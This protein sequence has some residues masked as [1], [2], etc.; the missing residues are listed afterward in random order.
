MDSYMVSNG[1]NFLATWI[2]FKNHFLE[3]GWMQNKETMALRTLLTTVDLF[4][5]IMVE[6]PAWI[7]IH[8]NSI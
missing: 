8:W 3:V 5:F 7:K 2:I 1:S 4:Y 6:D